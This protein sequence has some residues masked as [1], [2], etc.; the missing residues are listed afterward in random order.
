MKLKVKYS[1]KDEI[2]DGAE[3]F[4]TERDGA[5]HLDAEGVKTE[6]DF[7]RVET[8]MRRAKEERNALRERVKAAFGDDDLDDVAE[9]LRALKGKKPS[10]KPAP[11]GDDIEAR[12][13][14]AVE[15]A[16]AP[17]KR[18]LATERE[19]RTGA[20][21][22]LQEAQI[23]DEVRKAAAAAN[24]R[25]EA[26]DDVVLRASGAFQVVEGKV[27]TAGDDDSAYRAPGDWIADV[28]K[29][30]PHYLAASVG[31]G[32]TG[33]ARGGSVGGNPWSAKGWSLTAQGAY[34]KEHG[35][36]KAAEMAKAA[37]VK[38]GATR[39]AS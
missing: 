35:Q 3:V 11:G 27:V 15:A 37:G 8:A 33:G 10:D 16:L 28:L 36:E 5:W 22:R 9:Q 6:D 24:V 19:A 13:A 29:D 25:P 32:A 17:V 20:E 31:G 1:S 4:Y 7:A 38:L 30:R 39:A 34:V 21:T 2:P 23:A 26:L 12:V 18:E 14:R